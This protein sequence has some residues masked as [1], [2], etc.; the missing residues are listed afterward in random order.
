MVSYLH[1]IP[2]L[3]IFSKPDIQNDSLTIYYNSEYLLPI[4]KVHKITLSKKSQAGLVSFTHKESGKNINILN[5]HLTS[6]EDSKKAQVRQNETKALLAGIKSLLGSIDNTIILMDSN[7]SNQ[8]PGPNDEPDTDIVLKELENEKFTDLLQGSNNECYKM[9]HGNGGQPKKFGLLMYD[10]ID[11]IAVSPDLSGMAR[12]LREYTNA[13]IKVTDILGPEELQY[14]KN[15]KNDE[16]RRKE[17]K[18]LCENQ[19]WS[20]KVGQCVVKGK[21][22]KTIFRIPKGDPYLTQ[23]CVGICPDNTIL[24]QDYQRLLYP[25][26]NCASDHPPCIASIYL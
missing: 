8:Y 17:L 20:D 11:K 10:Q 18:K 9:R 21:P 6:G 19:K 16:V 25:N 14:I 7:S 3:R 22:N 15:L 12:S 5:A 23:N 1:I 2:S 26:V 24:P 13:F 4:S